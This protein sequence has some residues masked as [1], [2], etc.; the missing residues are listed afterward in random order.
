MTPLASMPMYA[1]PELDGAFARLWTAIAEALRARGI[2]APDTL[3]TVTDLMA[4]WRE[5]ALLFSQTC[6]MPYRLFLHD[7][8]TLIGT[9]DF[10]VAGC[11]PGHYHSVFVVRRDDGERQLEDFAG[12]R[13]A[14][15]EP[16]SQSG[17][18]APLNHASALGFGFSDRIQSHAHGRSARMVAEGIADIAAIDAVSWRHIERFDAFAETLAVIATT[19][20]STPG[21]PYITAQK[22]HAAALS[23][24]VAD[25]IDGMSVED[26]DLTGLKS[27]VQ[28][29]KEA[30][31][32]VETPPEAMK[33][34]HLA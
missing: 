12:R 32:K 18:A 27:L 3:A 24:T 9:P 6:G 5:P 2:A 1:R 25:V 29:P 13:F 7:T 26:C 28:I 19:A 15:N 20:P 4:H 34:L 8:V 33:A 21:L 22:D 23:E 16:T 30:Y 17:Y 14:F 10:G 31:L 11:P